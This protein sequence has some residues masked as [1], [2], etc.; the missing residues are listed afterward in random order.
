MRTGQYQPSAAVAGRS[1]TTAGW[2]NHHNCPVYCDTA[3]HGRASDA[4][5]EKGEFKQLAQHSFIH[6]TIFLTNQ[7]CLMGFINVTCVSR[8]FKAGSTSWVTVALPSVIWHAGESFPRDDILDC[9]VGVSGGG[10][11]LRGLILTSLV[12]GLRRR[13]RLQQASSAA[14]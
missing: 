8:F 13:R 5:E 3:G 14:C 7:N 4:P 10:P 6:Q 2:R 9:L 11:D 12:W 1:R